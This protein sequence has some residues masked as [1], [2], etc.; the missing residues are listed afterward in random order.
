MVTHNLVQYTQVGSHICNNI[1]NL[2][3]IYTRKKNGD[4]IFKQ[5]RS[6]DDV[7]IEDNCNVTSVSNSVSN[8]VAKITFLGI[9]YT[10]LKPLKL[11]YSHR[12]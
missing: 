10:N 2:L 11:S 1:V 6:N 5:P 4:C 8:G 7:I 9:D 3:K 12:N